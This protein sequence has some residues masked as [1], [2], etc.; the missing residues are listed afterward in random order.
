LTVPSRKLVLLLLAIAVVETC[1]VF[2]YLAAALRADLR[3][4]Q[5]E[6]HE[7]EGDHGAAKAMLPTA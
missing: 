2:V 6:R 3:R 7:R 5:S 1:V 4:V